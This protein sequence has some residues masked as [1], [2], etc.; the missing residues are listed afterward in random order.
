MVFIAELKI[1]LQVLWAFLVNYIAK[2]RSYTKPFEFNLTAG[3][4]QWL[5]EFRKPN[6]KCLNML[7]GDVVGKAGGVGSRI[8]QWP[9]QTLPS[10]YN[11]SACTV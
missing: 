3:S 6:C 1:R 4:H 8:K 2:T 7:V 9:L 5:K 11:Q 10:Y